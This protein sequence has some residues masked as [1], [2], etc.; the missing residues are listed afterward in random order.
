MC[1]CVHIYMPLYVYTYKPIATVS[2]SI[3]TKLSEFGEKQWLF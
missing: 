3:E 1:V 2:F